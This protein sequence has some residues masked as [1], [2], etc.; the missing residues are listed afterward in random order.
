MKQKTYTN[1]TNGATAFVGAIVG[2]AV[3]QN[4]IILA[5]IGFIVGMIFLSVIKS[6]SRVT[7]DERQIMLADKAARLTYIVFA[8]TVGIG[9]TIISILFPDLTQKIGFMFS[10]LALYLMALYSLSYF[11]LNNK[12]GG[13]P[14]A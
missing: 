13:S 11:Y 12:Y 4:N 10:S 14:D 3:A 2:V 8:L 1:L 9:G 6:K 5:I 7:A